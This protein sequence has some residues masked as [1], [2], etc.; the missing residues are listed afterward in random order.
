[1]APYPGGDG[2]RPWPRA[3]SPQAGPRSPR[4]RARA[5]QAFTV[6]RS[7]GP[8]A[9][10][11]RGRKREGGKRENFASPSSLTSPPQKKVPPP[12]NPSEA[13]LLGAAGLR[14]ARA[15]RCLF[16]CQRTYQD[17]GSREALTRPGSG[18]SAGLSLC[19]YTCANSAA[20]P[21]LIYSP[22]K[23]SA[24]PPPPALR[25]PRQPRPGPREAAP[26]HGGELCPRPQPR[27]RGL[28]PHRF[29][30]PRDAG[31]LGGGA[32]PP[33]ARPGGRARGAATRRGRTPR[34]R[35]DLP[36]APRARPRAA[37]AAPPPDTPGEAGAAPGP[38][39][40]RRRAGEGGRGADARSRSGGA[41]RPAAPWAGSPRS[42]SAGLP[43]RPEPSLGARG[44]AGS[45]RL[46]PASLRPFL[47]GENKRQ[48]SRDRSAEHLPRATPSFLH[49]SVHL[50]N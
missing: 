36:V 34:P 23:G 12:P 24:F 3:H 27:A 13:L 14:A 43:I 39:K 17:A 10:S 37:Q 7:R 21:R 35:T 32:A 5:S 1:M 29:L 18:C 47:S 16:G 8:P 4:A 38:G 20:L 9:T 28:V 50:P 33:A 42:T 40:E 46:Q 26:G 31:F 49:P 19:F 45:V 48:P 25:P 22:I 11:R 2:S 6:G 15:P 44:R 41:R 30:P